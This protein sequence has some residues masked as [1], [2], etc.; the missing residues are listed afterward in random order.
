MHITIKFL[1]NTK[2]EKINTIKNELTRSFSNNKKFSVVLKEIGAF[3]SL[4]SPRII[5]AGFLDRDSGLENFV[6]LSESLFEKLGFPKE[7]RAFRAHA[8]I[9]RVRSGKNLPA[10]IEQLKKINQLLEPG[11]FYIDKLCLMESALTGKG[12]VYST[13]QEIELF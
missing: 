6:N 4:D 3:P 8:T 9:G 2:I 5:W 7:I 11:D 12:P 13:I 1:G 10:L